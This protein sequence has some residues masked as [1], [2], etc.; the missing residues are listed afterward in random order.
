MRPF[1]PVPEGLEFSGMRWD[2]GRGLG[3]LARAG[4]PWGPWLG[5]LSLPHRSSW[6]LQSPTPARWPLHR[7]SPMWEPNS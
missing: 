3:A 2:R 7:P 4:E 1:E 5:F 6:F